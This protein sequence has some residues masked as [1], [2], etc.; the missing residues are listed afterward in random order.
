ME[1]MLSNSVLEETEK[2]NKESLPSKDFSLAVEKNMI[3][4]SLTG[5]YN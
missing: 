3:I 2:H 1:Y 4:L 5:I